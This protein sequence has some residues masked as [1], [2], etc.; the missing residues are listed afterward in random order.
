MNPIEVV[1]YHTAGE[2]FRIVVGGAPSL[3]GDTVLERRADA[4]ANHDDVRR[5]IINEPR[6]HADQYGCFVV[7]PDDDDAQFGVVFFHKDGYSTAC[8]HGTIAAATWAFESG[9]LTSV[10]GANRI[11]IDVP[12]GRVTVEVDVDR[13]G[14]VCSATFINVASYVTATEIPLMLDGTTMTA[15]MSYGG[16]FYVSVDASRLG[17]TVTPDHIDR[18]IALGR[19]TKRVLAD[20]P[21]SRHPEKRLSGIYGVIFYERLGLRHQRNIT[22]F[23]DGALDRSPCGSGTSARLALLHAAGEL[24]VGETLIHDSVIQTRF[25]GRVVE[26]TSADGRNAV[27]T[28]VMGS[29]HRTGSA[30]FSLDPDDPLGLGFQI[31]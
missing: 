10:E 28:S 20:H 2:P 26:T 29:A 7:S 3:S 25:E 24:G 13:D 17:L 4:L 12:S 15:D 21:G 30:R 1:D 16:A 6:G 9:L 31:R 27:I 18:F 5:L 8:G 22:V 11:A 19:E 23:A 14:R